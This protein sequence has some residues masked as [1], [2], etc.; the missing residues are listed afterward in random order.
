MELLGQWSDRFEVQL[1]LQPK[2]QLWQCQIF[3]QLCW[4]RDQTCVPVFP[5]CHQSHCA[6]AGTPLFNCWKTK[7][8]GSL[9]RIKLY[10]VC[11]YYLLQWPLR[12]YKERKW[13]LESTNSEF[14]DI[15]KARIL[16]VHKQKNRA[17]PSRSGS[18]AE[19]SLRGPCFSPAEWLRTLNSFCALECLEYQRLID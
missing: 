3:N 12:R 19:C 11:H 4:A 10:T 7:L 5:R 16:N 14:S 18:L 13:R 17:H 9:Q 15:S 8:S 2:L 1:Q 6:T